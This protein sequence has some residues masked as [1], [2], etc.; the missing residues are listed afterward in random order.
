M[1]IGSAFAIGLING[2]TNNIQEEKAKRAA[3][4]ASLDDLR[5]SM[6]EA[7]SDDNAE[8][9]DAIGNIIDGG[10]EQIKGLGRVDLFGRPSQQMDLDFTKLRDTVNS[11]DS[12]GL[13]FGSGPN[14]ITFLKD[15]DY[16]G[17]SAEIGMLIADASGK[18][19]DPEYQRRFNNM[20]QTEK[21]RLVD[22]LFGARQQY[23]SNVAGDKNIDI[24]VGQNEQTG[25]QG[26]YWL[27][28]A[29]KGLNIVPE[30]APSRAGL[31]V[32]QAEEIE[33][34]RN[35]YINNNPKAAAKG[36]V[37]VGVS[38]DYDKEDGNVMVLND[39]QY[40]NLATIADKFDVETD[41]FFYT[42]QTSITNDLGMSAQKSKDLLLASLQIPSEIRNVGALDPDNYKFKLEQN[43]KNMIAAVEKLDKLV[44][45][46]LQAMAYVLAP[47]MTYDMAVPESEVGFGEVKKVKNETIQNYILRKMYGDKAKD[48]KF[49]DFQEQAQAIINTSNSLS[50]FKA[51]VQQRVL[52]GQGPEAAGSLI[53]GFGGIFGLKDGYIKTLVDATTTSIGSALNI[54]KKAGYNQY[55]LGTIAEEGRINVYNAKQYTIEYDQALKERIT[56][57]RNTYGN[58][59]A[60]LEAL[61]ITL[62]FEMARAADPSGRLSNQDIELQYKKLGSPFRNPIDAL[63]ALDIVM[64]EFEKK[65]NQVELLQKLGSSTRQGTTKDFLV[66]DG[67]ITADYLLR[68]KE[69][70]VARQTGKVDI[71]QAPNSYNLEDYEIFSGETATSKGYTN[72]SGNTIYQISPKSSPGEAVRIGGAPVFVDSM[73][74][75]VPP[76]EVVRPK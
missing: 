56:L 58:N 17:T 9:G 10:E 67:L 60:E 4:K 70:M 3:D 5:M 37:L 39:I 42:W 15:I 26:L 18:F 53:L 43:E 76:E 20:D 33:V 44:G 31:T 50:N 40:A 62:A 2:F 11:V 52:D 8:L 35:N 73:G 7:Y 41:A 68:N 23:R 36:T 59:A 48:V 74:N 72:K 21:N 14:K 19:L 24:D 6:I 34:I 57:A 47:H 54:G 29:A 71:M 30:G 64:E 61:R 63:P 27:D 25:F 49:S 69:G 55:D 65:R 13:S 66:I 45:N 46:D 38:G 12:T 32:T 1:G 16:G 51:L 22:T 75:V 28:Q